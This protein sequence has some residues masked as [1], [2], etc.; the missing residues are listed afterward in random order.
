M[1]LKEVFSVLTFMHY[2]YHHLF[3]TRELNRQVR[4]EKSKCGFPGQDTEQGCL[5]VSAQQFCN[6]FFLQ[7]KTKQKPQSPK[8]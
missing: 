4:P 3:T 5:K 2:H 1:R 8:D 6:Q 7:F